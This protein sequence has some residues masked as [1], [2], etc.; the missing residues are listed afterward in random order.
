[1]AKSHF[2]PTK[3]S[4]SGMDVDRD[5]FFNFVAVLVGLHNRLFFLSIQ[6]NYDLILRRIYSIRNASICFVIFKRR[7]ET[8]RVESGI[9]GQLYCSI[10]LLF[11]CKQT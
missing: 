11:E 9:I 7:V 3:Y 10:L 4:T 1:M 5:I 2:V 6:I 8:G